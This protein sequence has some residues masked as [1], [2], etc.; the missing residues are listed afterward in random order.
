MKHGENLVDRMTG[1][2]L[3]DVVKSVGKAAAPLLVNTCPVV[4]TDA[5]A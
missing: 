2:G 5:M 3:F 1:K 4:P